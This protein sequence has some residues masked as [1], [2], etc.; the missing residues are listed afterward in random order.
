MRVSS[1]SF[2]DSFLYQSN[3]L[4]GQQNALQNQASTGLKVSLPEDNPAAMA[5][6]LGLQTDASANS[7][8]Q[9]NITQLQN[10][11]TTAY[12]AMNGLQTL[13]AKANEIATSASSG[14]TS[15]QQ[16]ASDATVVSGLLKQAIQIGN[17]KD[18]SG[19]YIFVGTKLSSP[20]FVATTDANGNVTA[21]TYQG[22]TNVSQV[23]IA[24][25]V[26]VSAQT[27]G[28]NTSGTGPR[29]LITDSRYGADLFNH[30]ISLQNNL[31]AGNSS[32][33]I[34]TDSPQL[35][36]DESNIAYQVGSNGVFQS[37]LT[38]TS[39][40][41]TQESTNLTAQISNTTSADLA[42]TIVR[43]QQTQTAYQAALESGKMVMGL[44]LLNY[45]P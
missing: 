12:N 14:T 2:T 24:P 32:A 23:E 25:N 5:Q 11:A 43:L 20:P 18:S 33:I 34:A 4:Q 45:L 13:I 31:T 40:V 27:L 29:G 9:S 17:S 15:S 44:S 8:Y 7:Q 19:N 28:A 30:L 35:A 16:F 3:L 38:N 41:A 22:N 42:T 6:V 21:V 39:N 37:T 36:K 26:T 10:S 1:S